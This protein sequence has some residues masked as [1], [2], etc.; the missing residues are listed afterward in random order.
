MQ[1]CI[2]AK[3]VAPN[4][5]VTLMRVNVPR[6]SSNNFSSS[7]RRSRRDMFLQLRLYAREGVQSANSKSPPFGTSAQFTIHWLAQPNLVVHAAR[8]RGCMGRTKKKD[9]ADGWYT[10]ILLSC[11]LVRRY[12][13]IALSLPTVGPPNHLQPPHNHKMA[14]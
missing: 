5:D 1:S 3:P 11:S 10:Q 4:M 8:F 7:S 6:D 14:W 12:Q 2:Y 13:A 9:W